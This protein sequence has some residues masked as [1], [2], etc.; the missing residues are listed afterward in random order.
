MA[1]KWNFQAPMVQGTAPAQAHADI[2]AGLWERELGRDAFFGPATD[3]YHRNPPNAWSAIDKKGPRPHVFDT[4][5]I[6]HITRSPWHAAEMLVNDSIR[7][8]YWKMDNQFTVL[9]FDTRD[10]LKLGR[11]AR[12]Y[13]LPAVEW[14]PANG[15]RNAPDAVRKIRPLRQLAKAGAIARYLYVQLRYRIRKA[16]H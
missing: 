9:M 8:R 6:M 11:H 7:I 12:H 3:F 15:I 1:A 10:P 4:R 13:E 16:I 14:L 2:P 5:H